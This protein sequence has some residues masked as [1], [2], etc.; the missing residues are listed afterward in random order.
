MAAGIWWRL[1]DGVAAI[2]GGYGV[3]PLTV[4]ATQVFKGEE[5][6]VHPVIADNSCGNLGRGRRL[7]RLRRRFVRKCRRGH[8]GIRF[9]R[10][11]R[12]RPLGA[13]MA[14]EAGW[15]HRKVS[16]AISPDSFRLTGKPSRARPIAGVRT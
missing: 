14:P 15:L 13:N 8:A 1:E 7:L 2:C 12:A 11:P 6:S 5:S 10:G 9:P 16:E 4:E 3:L